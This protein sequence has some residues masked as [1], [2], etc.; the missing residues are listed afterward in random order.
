MVAVVIDKRV[1]QERYPT[2]AHP[3]HL[4]LGYLLSGTAVI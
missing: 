1:L 2:P 3:Y 4:A